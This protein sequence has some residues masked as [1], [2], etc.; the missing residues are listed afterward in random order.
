M[1]WRPMKNRH[2]S[3]IVLILA[4]F[5]SIT[6]LI[7]A[8]AHTPPL[9]VPTTSHIMASPNP[10]G[11]TQ[12]ANITFWLDQAPPTATNQGGCRWMNLTVKITR[13][14]GTTETKGPFSSDALGQGFFL[15]TPTTIGTYIFIFS[16]AG[17]VVTLNS[18]LNGSPG[19]PSDYINDTFQASSA[20]TS[21]TVQQAQVPM[22]TPIPPVGNVGG[23]ISSS[24]LWSKANSPYTLTS[25]VIVSSG[26]TLTIEPGVA[27]N[28]NGRN[29]KV[30]GQLIANG[31][32]ANK[33]YFFGGDLNVGISI[34]GSA[35]IWN[36]IMTGQIKAGGASTII[37]NVVTGRIDVV[38][39]SH[40]IYN[41]TV[42][43]SGLAD[44]I[45]FFDSAN[46]A[47]VIS[48]NVI[49]GAWRGIAVTT[50]SKAIIER[51]YIYNNSWGIVTGSSSYSLTAGADSTILNN[52]LE[53]NV[54]GIA[55]I[56]KFAPS[57]GFN[58]F[59]NNSQFALSLTGGNDGNTSYTWGTSNIDAI[60]NW[61]GTSNPQAINTVILDSK[62]NTPSGTVNYVPFLT[63]PNDQSMP[64]PRF[65]PA[66]SPAPSPTPTSTP[67]PTP[68]PS[69]YP[70][71]TPSQ[72]PWSSPSP[73]SSPLPTPQPK[74]NSA[75]QLMCKATTSSSNLKVNI[76]GSLTSGGKSVPDASVFISYSVT[77]GASWNDLTTVNTDASGEFAALWMPSVTGNFLVRAA[78]D[79]NSLYE[80]TSLI[81]N[82]VVSPF[83]GQSV[84]SVTSNST[85]SSFSFDSAK[86]E[87]TFSVAG[88]S[89]SAGYVD[90]YIPKSLI[91]DISGLTVNL[92]GNQL[93]Y[94][95]NS[96][97]DSWLVSFT[98][99]HSTHQV[100]VNLFSDAN[101]SPASPTP[102]PEFP[103]WI[104]L[105]ALL[106]STGL[107]AVALKRKKL[108]ASSRHL[109][110]FCK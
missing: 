42:Y 92:D 99:H 87:L 14:D 55:V 86:K 59:L 39:G 63:K 62:Y 9:N 8:E 58:N 24:T 38:N 61:W 30:D 47:A 89:G 50:G 29:I 84:F 60:Y 101:G 27:V 23:L 46:G 54:G 97:D 95:S 6:P 40:V 85:L 83:E 12:T 106:M 77:N 73:Y 35:V 19:V 56:G 105:P 31:T 53:N 11:I 96:Q 75:L 88:Q 109:S 21:L 41:N 72:T 36:C 81:V 78:W 18:P 74:K 2:P 91:T 102:I 10:I 98:Y 70:S 108:K 22:P 45:D 34:A 52:T 33:I 37:G 20:I 90:M 57:I 94:T 110:S 49:T 16:F 1:P 65:I 3:T 13:P 100:T 5:L 64:N 69:S 93:S 104:I 7:L 76:D 4:L 28:L 43:A 32:S 107:V 68:Y 15:Y 80:S 48:D 25:D 79:G 71:P 26:T 103:S 17:Q 66:A 67:S 51:N 82:L 44:G